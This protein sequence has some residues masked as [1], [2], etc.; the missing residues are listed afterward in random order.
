MSHTGQMEVSKYKVKAMVTKSRI[1]CKRWLFWDQVD[2]MQ[3]IAGEQTL[4]ITCM[5]VD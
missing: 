2:L 4:F 3:H 1:E 5:G